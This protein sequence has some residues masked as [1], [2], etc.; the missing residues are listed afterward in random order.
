MASAHQSDRFVRLASHVGEPFDAH[1]S[2]L[3]RYLLPS[4]RRC[5]DNWSPL[6]GAKNNRGDSFDYELGYVVRKQM[7]DARI[8]L[9]D[10]V[11]IVAV[12][13]SMVFALLEYCHRLFSDPAFLPDI[14]EPELGPVTKGLTLSA[15]PGHAIFA[16]QISISHVDDIRLLGSV[17]AERQ[18]A[19]LQLFHL[20]LQFVWEHEM[21]HAVLGHLLFLRE[22]SA[23]S[24]VGLAE[25]RQALDDGTTDDIW[26]YIESQADDG[27][28]FS[29]IVGPIIR[30]TKRPYAVISSADE[31]LARDVRFRFLAAALLSHFLMLWDIGTA[32]NDP[33][34]IEASGD[35]PSTLSRA[36]AALLRSGQNIEHHRDL[37]A[38]WILIERGRLKASQD[39]VDYSSENELFRPF[40]WLLRNDVAPRLF[41]DAMAWDTA[42]L[43]AQFADFAFAKAH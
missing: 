31:E 38:A 1:D 5:S 27:A 10:G 15:A 26:P 33:Y 14:G 3:E 39:L 16:G 32:G 6:K 17:C 22:H 36:L 11:H 2:A 43:K 23:K 34:A 8:E 21:A 30:F 4:L 28:A 24:S 37:E 41:A 35:H 18:A 29:V 7:P 9:H 19:A 42:R 12:Y 25:I 20:A 13:H 40:R